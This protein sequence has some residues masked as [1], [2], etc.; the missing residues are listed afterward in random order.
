MIFM[1]RINN[2]YKIEIYEQFRSALEQSGHY[3][4]LRMHIRGEEHLSPKQCRGLDGYS[5]FGLNIP[6]VVNAIESQETSLYHAFPPPG[7]VE[8]SYHQIQP[9]IE[10]VIR[11]REE[12]VI[13]YKYK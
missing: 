10:Q 4:I 1:V 12:R 13:F 5:F 8:Y 11:I 2:K 6:Q 7:Y 3:K 9:K